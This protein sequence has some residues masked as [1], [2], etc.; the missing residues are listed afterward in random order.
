Q[1][2]FPGYKTARTCSPAKRS[3]SREKA[4]VIILPKPAGA[5]GWVKAAI[6]A[7]LTYYYLYHHF[8]MRRVVGAF[9]T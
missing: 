6:T 3:A 7:L 8:L 1:A 5:H 4:S 9:W 2:P